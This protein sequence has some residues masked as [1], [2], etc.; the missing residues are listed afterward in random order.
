VFPWDGVVTGFAV[1]A[2]KKGRKVFLI[3]YPNARNKSR[4]LTFSATALMSLAKARDEAR[5]KLQQVRDGIDPA[6]A[7]DERLAE[8]TLREVIVKWQAE[9]ADKNLTMKPSWPNTK[10]KV[11]QLQ[12]WLGEWL[13]TS[14]TRRIIAVWHALNV[15]ADNQRSRPLTSCKSSTSSSPTC[16]V[17]CS[18]YSASQSWRSGRHN[19]QKNHAKLH[20][21]HAECKSTAGS[22]R[23][24]IGH[25]FADQGCA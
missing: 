9:Y 2:T 23:I 7:R 16:S 20:L 22:P 5:R 21:R 1:K 4:R 3:Q 11:K 19:S 17:S 15:S 14:I 25:A 18:R 24:A 13:V 12:A 10:S 6:T 8:P